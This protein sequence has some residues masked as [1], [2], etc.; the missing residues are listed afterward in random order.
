MLSF[1]VSFFISVAFAVA[2]PGEWRLERMERMDRVFGS[3][4]RRHA[5]PLAHVH[6][7]GAELWRQRVQRRQLAGVQQPRVPDEA[8]DA[9]AE[10]EAAEA[11][12]DVDEQWSAYLRSLQVTREID[13]VAIGG[14]NGPAP[15]PLCNGKGVRVMFGK[16]SKCEWCDGQGYVD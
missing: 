9:L 13:A 2:E 7:P 1:S 12:T 6:E 4:R 15:C 14:E 8:A 5:V 3:V 10:R 11:R 16:E